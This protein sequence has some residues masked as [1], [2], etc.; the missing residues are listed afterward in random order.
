MKRRTL[1]MT[2]GLLGCGLAAAGVADDK[3]HWAAKAAS[4]FT[5]DEKIIV[6]PD[7]PWCPADWDHSGTVDL[8][9]LHP[10][11]DQWFSGSCGGDVNWDGQLTVQ[12]IFDFLAMLAVGS[13]PPVGEPDKK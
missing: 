3:A 6:I 5:L 11:L 9:D 4:Q 13:C 1:N 2:A 12:D 7:V 10:F 8:S